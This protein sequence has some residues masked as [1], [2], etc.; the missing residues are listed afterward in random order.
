[1]SN[2]FAGGVTI[3]IGGSG[4]GYAS[5]TAFTSTGGGANC[6]VTGD[7]GV[8]ERCAFEYYVYARGRVVCGVGVGMYFGTDDCV[9]V[10][11]GDWRDADGD[12]DDGLRDVY[13]HRG[14]SGKYDDGDV[15]SALL[16]AVLVCGSAEQYA[17]ADVVS[18]F[19]DRSAS[20]RRSASAVT[21]PGGTDPEM[22]SLIDLGRWMELAPAASVRLAAEWLRVRDRSGR[23]VPLLANAAQRAFEERRGRQ[24]IV[25]KARQMGIT[26]WVAGRFFLRT[27]TKPGTLTL[28]VA[29][30]REAAEAI[31]RVV[32]RMWEGL[33]EMWREG[34]LKR[35]KANAG[36][37]VFPELDS[38]YRVASAAD[39]NAG[40]GLSVQNLHCSEVSRWPGDAAETLAGLRA[41]L[42]PA[43]E[44]VLES[45]PNG[46]VWRVL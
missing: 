2:L 36:Q 46:G 18:E 15:Q 23:S 28:Q 35:S 26:T 21:P 38:E 45:T 13:D 43:G 30:T 40:R 1:M 25:L 9:D 8:G 31:F 19:I 6:V 16:S 42:A 22:C 12:A 29:H 24:N 7:D 34:Q 10:A 4:T 39:A 3:A 14:G 17:F 27:I 41:A 44:L 5:S 32:Q 37:M 20:E 33:P 11:D